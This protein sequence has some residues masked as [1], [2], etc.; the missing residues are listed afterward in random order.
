MAI[1]DEKYEDLEGILILRAMILQTMR[2][3]GSRLEYYESMSPCS[4]I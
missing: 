4:T 3:H 2:W 1:A